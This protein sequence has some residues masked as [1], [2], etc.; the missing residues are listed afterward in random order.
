MPGNLSIFTHSSELSSAQFH[1]LYELDQHH[2]PI[3]WTKQAWQSYF[4]S[5]SDYL[6]MAYFESN[7]P[8]VLGFALWQTSAADSFAHLLKI[9]VD[10]HFRQ[11]GAGEKIMKASLTALNSKQIK[12]YFL[13]VEENNSAAVTLY[14]K[15]G[16]K[17][18]HKKEKFYSNGEAA[19]IM[20]LS[21]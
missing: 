20:T 7:S 21:I 2:F 11:K 14:K 8:Q 4:D 9:A 1:A 19:L 16:F 3:P 15:M 10:S 5:H 18:I 12:D 6:I 17:T 13:E